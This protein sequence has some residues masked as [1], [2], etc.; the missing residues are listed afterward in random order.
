MCT[1]NFEGPVVV[2]FGSPSGRRGLECLL[3]L[4]KEEPYHHH[5]SNGGPPNDC[6]RPRGIPSKG[7]TQVPGDV[8]SE[9]NFCV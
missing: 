4:R 5:R 2:G 1:R 9:K 8:V 3:S 7:F 6:G